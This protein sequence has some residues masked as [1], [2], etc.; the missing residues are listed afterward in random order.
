VLADDERVLLVQ[1]ADVGLWGLP[2]GWVEPGETVV[3][4]VVREV[5]EET[6]LD[7]AVERLIGVYSDPASQ[8]FAYPLGPVVQF[9]TSCFA[10]RVIGGTAQADGREALDAAFCP[11]HDLPF[12]LL[13]MHPQWLT[14]ALEGE[15]AAR[16]R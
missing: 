14:D 5:R 1:R 13:P 11:L 3:E 16:V 12:D 10:C 15:V 4:A 7:V 9:V 6:G 2:S 8:V